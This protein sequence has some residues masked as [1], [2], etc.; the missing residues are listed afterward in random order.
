MRKKR[1]KTGKEEGR[2]GKVFFCSLVTNR[3]SIDQGKCLLVS[4]ASEHCLTCE[5]CE[6]QPAK[7]CTMWD[8]SHN[9]WQEVLGAARGRL[10]FYHRTETTVKPTPCFQVKLFAPLLIES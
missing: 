9:R 6:H 1:E 10:G 2:A 8:C 5:Q 4:A 7:K 3:M